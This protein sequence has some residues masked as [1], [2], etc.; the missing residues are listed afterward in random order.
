LEA[1]DTTRRLQAK[2]LALPL[3]APG[4]ADAYLAMCEACREEL[5]VGDAILAEKERLLAGA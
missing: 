3:E 2:Y 4:K 5:D 1:H